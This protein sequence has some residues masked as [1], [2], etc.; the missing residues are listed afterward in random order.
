MGILTSSA[1][2]PSIYLKRRCEIEVKIQAS[3][4]AYIEMKGTKYN[5]QKFCRTRTRNPWGT[6]MAYAYDSTTVDAHTPT[7]VAIRRDYR[8]LRIGAAVLASEK[9]TF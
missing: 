3:A 6:A 2:P 7:K 8:N 4:S 1:F 5:K 9:Y